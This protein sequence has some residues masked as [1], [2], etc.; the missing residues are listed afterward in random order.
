MNEMFFKL[1]E[2]AI[3]VLL[4]AVLALALEYLRRRLGT[5]RLQKIQHELA[6]KQSLARLAVL[7][8]EQSCRDLTSP[9]KLAMATKWLSGRAKEHGIAVTPEQI[10]GLTEAAIRTFK[11]LYGSD[12]G[13]D[14]KTAE[15]A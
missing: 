1:L 7:Y 12:W 15:P 14:A 11:D 13:H 10:E 3:T 9:E 4:P 6:T 5:E 8:V 2:G